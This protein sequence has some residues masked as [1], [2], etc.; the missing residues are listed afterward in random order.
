MTSVDRFLEVVW[1]MQG[2]GYAFLC[3]KLPGAEWQDRRWVQSCFEFSGTSPLRGR[4]DGVSD[5]YFLPALFSEREHKSVYA[6]PSRWL[7]ADLDHDRGFRGRIPKALRPTLIW[8]T[9]PHNYQALWLLDRAVE[10]ETLRALNSRLASELTG[11]ISGA[12]AQQALRIPGTVHSKGA[13]FDVKL[14]QLPRPTYSFED[15]HAQLRHIELAPAAAGLRLR[16]PDRLPRRDHIRKRY[17]ARQLGWAM[18]ET[19]QPVRRGTRSDVLWHTERRLYGLGMSPEEVYVMVRP[20]E[21]SQSKYP[22]HEAQWLEL[23]RHYNRLRNA[24]A[25]GSTAESTTAIDMTSSRRKRENGRT[26]GGGDYGA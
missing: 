19:R 22:R 26:S 12:D 21:W 20:T 23:C 2:S 25:R 11:D 6:R 13:P 5:L 8:R 3:R 9:S 10:P 18:R 1:G 24:S 7:W 4:G 16:L 15:L 17:G 14:L